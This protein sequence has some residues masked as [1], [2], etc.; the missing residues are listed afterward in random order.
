V[1]MLF[2]FYENDDPHIQ[3]KSWRYAPAV[4]EPFGT[5][6]AVA[7]ATRRPATELMAWL[8]AHNLQRDGFDL[9]A[10]IARTIAADTDARIGTLGLYTTP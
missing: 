1:Q 8:T 7:V 3:T 9:P 4:T 5:D 10:V 2:P 6:V